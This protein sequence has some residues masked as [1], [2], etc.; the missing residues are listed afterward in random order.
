VLQR[1][2]NL[3]SLVVKVEHDPGATTGAAAAAG[4][5]VAERVKHRIGVTV[6][7]EVVA[8]GSIERSVGKMRRLVDERPRR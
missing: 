3:D 5:E 6:Q 2:G 7:V 8:P 1:A 4:R